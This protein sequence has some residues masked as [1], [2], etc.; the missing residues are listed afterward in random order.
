MRSTCRGHRRWW[1]A[2]EWYSHSHGGT[3]EL[4]TD[5]FQIYGGW[6]IRYWK[7]LFLSRFLE[8]CFMTT[9]AISARAKEACKHNTRSGF[10]ISDIATD[11]EA[12]SITMCICYQLNATTMLEA[13]SLTPLMNHLYLPL[14]SFTGLQF[15]SF[16]PIHHLK[17]RQSSNQRSWARHRN[18]ADFKYYLRT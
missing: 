14:C 11:K 18:L 1:K 9:K 8:L 7:F 12:L 10:A 17:K 15:P 5:S 6:K 13:N 2:C 16:R 4:K 3:Q